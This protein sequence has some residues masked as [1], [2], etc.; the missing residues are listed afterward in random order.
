MS[1]LN[2]S[3]G[4]S[5]QVWTHMA[6]GAPW[7]LHCPELL[8]MIAFL[9]WDLPDWSLPSRF[10][11]TLWSSFWRMAKITSVIMKQ[12]RRITCE[13]GAWV[14]KVR[15][16]RAHV[17]IMIPTHLLVLQKHEQK[18]WGVL[19]SVTTKVEIPQ[20]GGHNQRRRVEDALSMFPQGT[21]PVHRRPWGCW[22]GCSRGWEHY[23]ATVCMSPG[24]AVPACSL[25]R[26][27]RGAS[28]PPSAGPSSALQPSKSSRG[29]PTSSPAADRG[30]GGPTLP[31]P[32][33]LGTEWKR[34]RRPE[35][36][37]AGGDLAALHPCGC[38][39][40]LRVP[41]S[42]GVPESGFPQDLELWVPGPVQVP[43]LNLK[44]EV[45]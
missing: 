38:S 1:G 20:E 42:L 16:T 22:A 45:L 8:H 37:Q 26:S 11:T 7:S 41:A 19:L 34:H 44:V 23:G 27:P 6:E 24:A 13:H 43:F 33:L 29:T 9:L 31:C 2:R 36:L 35:L 15:Q 5:Q 32:G 40:V 10:Q 3:W 4:W 17:S 28:S 12:I 21:G 25:W 14:E 18:H 39:L 30:W